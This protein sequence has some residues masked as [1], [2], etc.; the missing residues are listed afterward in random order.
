VKILKFTTGL[1]LL[2]AISGVGWLV[3]ER[4]KEPNGPQ[5]K[6]NSISLIAAVEVA[7]ATI[8]SIQLLRQFTGTL[9]S[10]SEFVVAPKVAGRIE[11]ISVDLGDTVERSEVVVRL[12]NAEY[13]QSLKLY[14]ADLAV[15]RA[16]LAEAKS[17]LEIAKRELERITTLQQRGVSSAAENDAARA[18]Y[19]ART[20]HVEVARAQILRAQAELE[21]ARIRL[22][23]SE[24][25]ANWRGGRNFRAV[26]ERYVDE[27]ETVTAN[28]PLLRIVDLDQLNGVLSVTERDYGQLQVGQ[29]VILD[30]DAFP[31]EKFNGRISRVSPVFD[32]ATRQARVEVTVENKDHRLKPGMFIRAN[33]E[34]EASASAVTVPEQALVTRN[35][36]SGVF[37]LND[38]G[39][40]VQ[41]KP[42][43]PGILQN[44]RVQLIDGS[45]D[46]LVVV[47]GQQLLDDGSAVNVVGGERQ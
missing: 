18:T 39:V 31:D 20:A 29:I 21:T 12:D 47:L 6:R 40:T 22:G 16:N 25:R 44:G 45:I 27:G 33:V 3:Y 11:E 2:V 26:A 28:Q 23:Y 41:W 10:K 34:L 35:N 42:V 46:G 8:Q 19:S 1:L 15:I 43:Q 36:E 13:T 37:V 14:Q 30:V 7:P 4:L 9:D 17:Q 24:V 32:E 38:D 5:K